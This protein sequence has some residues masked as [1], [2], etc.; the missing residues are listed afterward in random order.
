VVLVVATRGSANR[1]CSTNSGV[2]SPRVLTGAKATVCRSDARWLPSA[3]GPG[4][5][6]FA[7]EETDGDTAIAAKIE[8]G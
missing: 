3:G 2:E 7:V 5:R 1:A 6:Q 8:Q 4:P